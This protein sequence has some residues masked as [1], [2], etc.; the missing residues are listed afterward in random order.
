M[1]SN[2]SQGWTVAHRKAADAKYLRL[3]KAHTKAYR[4]LEKINAAL[5]RADAEWDRL[6][7][8]K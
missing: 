4:E 3:L 1:T 8:G 2:P 7:E 5:A 6:K